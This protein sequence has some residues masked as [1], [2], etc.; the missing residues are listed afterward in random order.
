[1]VDLLLIR[2]DAEARLGI[3]SGAREIPL[4]IQDRRVD[5]DGRFAC[6]PVMHERMESFCGDTPFVIGIHLPLHDVET[7]SCRLRVVNSTRAR[8]FRL[9]LLTGWRGNGLRPA[10]GP[11]VRTAAGERR[12]SPG[13]IL[14]DGRSGAAGRA[15]RRSSR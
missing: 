11:R 4:L 9:A 5:A 1:M 8:N 2:H 12:H 15:H 14:A 7:I 6:E 13:K 3:P 10:R